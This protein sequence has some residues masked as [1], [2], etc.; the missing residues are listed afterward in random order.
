MPDPGPDPE[1]EPCNRAA[2]DLRP[3]PGTITG[4]SVARDNGA[5]IVRHKAKITDG[6]AGY[7]GRG[8]VTSGDDDQREVTVR[9]VDADAELLAGLSG[10]TWGTCAG[11]RGRGSLM[12]VRTGRRLLVY[13]PGPGPLPAARVPRDGRHEGIPRTGSAD[14]HLTK[15]LTVPGSEPAPATAASPRPFPEC[16]SWTSESD[17]TKGK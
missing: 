4:V 12:R 15:L 3:I 6:V 1:L 2:R 17:R 9:M 7:G 11:L 8:R 14:V 16:A 13:L 10:W 5:K